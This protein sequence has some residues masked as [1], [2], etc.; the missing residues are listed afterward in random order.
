MKAL[1]EKRYRKS[2]EKLLNGQAIY[3]FDKII[4]KD[5]NFISTIECAKKISD[6]K[7]TVLITGE[8]GTGKEIF[9]QAIH[10]YSSRREKHFIAVNCGAIPSNLIEAEL[11]GYDEGAFTGAR[12]GGNAGKFEIADGGTIFLDEIGEMPL[13]MQVRLL[14]VIE[15]GVVSRIGSSKQVPVNVRIIA[16]TNRDL[17]EEV[18]LGNFRKD[19]FYRLNVLPIPLPPLRDRRE[20]IP[21]L[22]DYY[23]NK[24]GKKLNKEKIQIDK[25]IM[26]K[27]LQYEWPG[28]I[29][30][31]QN[32][33]ELM[34]NTEKVP[35]DILKQHKPTIIIERNV[36]EGF[37][38]IEDMKLEN[39]E[40]NHIIKVLKSFNGNIS[41]AANAMGI[42]RNT[43]YRKMKK[44]RIECSN[45]E[46]CSEVEQQSD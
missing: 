32:V 38:K 16:A 46:Q 44:Y 9:A 8:S 33:I 43:L 30:E 7:S 41:L 28:N 13:E 42:G 10:N 40:K 1:E 4:G 27:L 21:L 17:K 11:L 5:K 20:D 14:R 22:I 3:T 24:I 31:L 2:V 37:A 34:L 45:L 29:R 23:M 18:S 6:S 19:L 36:V 25:S 39:V 26:E 35:E 15:E 12:K